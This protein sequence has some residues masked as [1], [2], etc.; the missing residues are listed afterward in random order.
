MIRVLPL[1]FAFCF[2]FAFVGQAQTSLTGKITDEESNEPLPFCTVGLFQNGVQKNST[3]TDIDGNYTFT[4]IDPGTYE[5]FVSYTGYPE[6]RINNVLVRAGKA[7]RL[8]IKMSNQQGVLIDEIVVKEYRVPLVEVD[9]TTTGGTLTSE[10]IRQL[11]TRNI[12]ALA[13]TTAG[14][15]SSDEGGAITIKG[16]RSNATDY[17][18]DGIRVQSNLVPETEIDQMQVITG[19]IEAKYGDVTGGIISITT[20]GPSEK[21]SGGVEAESSN[22]LDP[23][24]NSLVGFNVSGPILKNADNRSILGF[25]FSGRYTTRLDDDPPAV[26]VFRIREDKLA[27]LE[28]NPVID[29]GGNAFVAADFLK[30]EDVVALDARPFEE[31]ERFDFTGKIDARLT[32]EIDITFTGAY[33]NNENQFT[34]G[35]WRLLNSHNNPF[36]TTETFRG[37]FRFRHRIGGGSDP[38][39][40][41]GRRSR[42]GIFQNI[43]YTL[44]AGYEKA[45][46]DQSDQRHGGNYFDYGYVGN[47]DIEWVPTFLELFNPETQEFFLFHTDYRQVLRNY[48]PG[49]INPVLANYNLGMGIDFNAGEGL[50]SQ[51]SD[52]LITNSGDVGSLLARGSFF[53]PNGTISNIYTNSWN[54]HSNVG[55][56]YNLA[57]EAESDVITFNAKVAFDLVPGGYDKG[58]HNVEMGFLYEER[59][60]RSYNVGPRT[61]WDIAR[62][63]ANNHILGIGENRDSVATLDVPGFPQAALFGLTIEEGSDNQF[64]RKVR[65]SL[66]VPLDQFVN[67]DGLRPDQLSLAMFSAR[68]LNDQGVLGYFGTDYLGNNFDGDFEEFFTATDASGV[69]T[70]PVAPNRPIYMAGYIQDKFTYKDIIFRLGV[71]VDSYNANTMVLKD[72]YS[73]YDIMGAGTYHSQFGGERPGNIG[74]EFNVY[75]NENGTSV[76]AYRD[77]DQWYRANGTPVNSAIEIEGIRS[78]LVFPKYADPN[79]DDDDNYI[80][81]RDFDVNA[82]FTDYETQ[83]NI[84][85]RLA[86]SFPIS[87]NANFFAHYDILVQRPPSNTI[88]T[89]LNYFYF[90]DN[91]GSLIN[92]PNLR[93]EKTIDFEVGFQ[94]KLS[95]N[96]ALKL[97]S[98]YK[99]MRDM[100]QQRTYFPVPIVNQY[101]T[102]DNQDFGTVK[103]ITVQ[104]DYR[105]LQ[106]G[107]LSLQANYTLQFADGT[108]S[109]A[110]SQ[111]GLTSRGNLRN[112]FPLDFD[113]R[114]RI[115]TTLDYRYGGTA[116]YNGPKISDVPIFANAGLN[117]QL[118]SV[119]GRPYTA[120]QI[121]VELGGTGTVGAINGARKPW[122]LTLNMRIDKTFELKNRY[123]LNV[124]LR[125][126]NL[127]DRRNIINVYSAT[128]SPTDDGFLNSPNG[129]DQI[130]NFLNSQRELDSYL[131]SYRWAL[132]NPNFYTLP[133]RMF[134]GASLIF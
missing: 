99:E 8:D 128:G 63:L 13:A 84:M 116:T 32:R 105:R 14:I 64:F 83:I 125:V 115:V 50:N 107:N 95:D 20:K 117:L 2:G 79:A 78:G 31:Q 3:G 124:Y 118:I 36:A 76:Q 127:L 85:P 129:Q 43:S 96:S 11:P 94:Q 110:N 49:D 47:F 73:L 18:V 55:S 106:R 52:W 60:N 35:G 93:P 103:G 61:L 80:K 119:S 40:S 97:A 75:L 87:G 54:F 37:N 70:F 133:R 86:F 58:R 30:E 126:S 6:Q 56:V 15:A 39:A 4:N 48:T 81:S 29:I 72:N 1:W 10:Q 28:S 121:P 114:H 108:G 130:D 77:G 41:S 26:D 102:Y 120:Q 100:I 67:I 46:S 69:R 62:Q 88:A 71:R 65:E 66:N 131:A 44:Q 38:S 112:L 113:E 59:I 22:F 51:V 42:A 17:Y 82:S 68:E 101:T 9:N 91:A 98:Y 7:E 25:R 122:N 90:I 33:S 57:S 45:L 23:Y 134:L 5:I 27:E 21:F 12:N 123:G 89:A 19:G 109:N 104:Y 132:L 34:P 111:R 92:N 53:A 74:D 16:S 24:D